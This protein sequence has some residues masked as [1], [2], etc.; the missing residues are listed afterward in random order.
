MTR[1][2]DTNPQ[3]IQVSL[4]QEDSFI[5]SLLDGH[6]CVLYKKTYRQDLEVLD[7]LMVAQGEHERPGITLA[8]P[9]QE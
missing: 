1:F 4:N 8:V 2:L 9:Q 5:Y 7:L 6:K 3:C